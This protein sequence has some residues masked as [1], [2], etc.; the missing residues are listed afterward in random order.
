MNWKRIWTGAIVSGILLWLVSYI[1]LPDFLG[2]QTSP[3]VGSV[4]RQ[5]LFGSLLDGFF[6]SWLYAGM[7]PRLG[8]GPKTA[9]IAGTAIYFIKHGLEI[10]FLAY[11]PSMWQTEGLW[12]L[13]PLLNWAKFMAAAYLAGWQYIEKAPS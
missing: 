7:R 5:N 8:R 2:Y 6:C 9:C 12:S 4:Q 13:F 1:E 11:V 10:L 3:L